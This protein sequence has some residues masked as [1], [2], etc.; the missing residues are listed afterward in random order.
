MVERILAFCLALASLLTG[1]RLHVFVAMSNHV[2]IVLTD[3]HGLLPIFMHTFSMLSAKLLNRHRGRKGQFWE[4][5]S[6]HALHLIDADA[7]LEKMAYALANPV[8]AGLVAHGVEW[9]GMI[10]HPEDWRGG[11][12]DDDDRTRTI[13]RPKSYFAKESSV[14]KEVGLRF[15]VPECLGGRPLDGVI[16]DVLQRRELLESLARDRVAKEERQFLGADAVVKTS[17]FERA[18]SQENRRELVPEVAGRD[19]ATRVPALRALKKFRKKYRECYEDFRAGLREVRFP[20]G[21]WG[22][23][24]VYGACV[25][26]G[27]DPRLRWSAAMPPP[28]AP[29]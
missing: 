27:A 21:T 25:A 7:V 22:P 11:E 20:V 3:V 26:D 6:Y 23:A 17:P 8:A 19:R 28:P 29:G 13:E 4:A 15:E 10:S 14:A 18:R 1:V 9:P 16:R 5:G 2:H 24:M 12:S